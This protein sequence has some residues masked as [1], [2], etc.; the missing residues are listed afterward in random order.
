MSA[1]FFCLVAVLGV[2]STADAVSPVP[3]VNNRCNAPIIVKSVLILNNLVNTGYCWI[4]FFALLVL[5]NHGIDSCYGRWLQFW[6][7]VYTTLYFLIV[8]FHL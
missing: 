6:K 5:E 1:N 7:I 8:G 3:T 4:I 2:M